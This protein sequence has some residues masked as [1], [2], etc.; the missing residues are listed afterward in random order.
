MVCTTIYLVAVAVAV[1]LAIARGAGAGADPCALAQVM[2]GIPYW[3][4]DIGG[5]GG[6]NTKTADCREL[7]VRWFQV[8]TM[9]LL[10]V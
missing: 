10:Y 5:F 7:V 3:T 6:G 8:R 4:T 9:L 1:A 2:S